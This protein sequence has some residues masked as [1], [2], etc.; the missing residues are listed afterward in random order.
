ML[1]SLFARVQSLSH[2]VSTL[3]EFFLLHCKLLA[4]RSGE[5]GILDPTRR[6]RTDEKTVILVPAMVQPPVR[7]LS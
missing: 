1:F 6:R 3:W 4:A 2:S 7:Y 5:G